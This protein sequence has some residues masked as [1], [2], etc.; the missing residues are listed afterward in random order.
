[1]EGSRTWG[2]GRAYAEAVCFF[3]GVSPFP[4]A[5]IVFAKP[6]LGIAGTARGGVAEAE[7]CGCIGRGVRGWERPR[8][9]EESALAYPLRVKLKAS[10]AWVSAFSQLGH[11]LKASA[12]AMW[13]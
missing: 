3:L 2:P 4:E 7:A 5:G 8:A 9:G 1:M 10:L 6:S 11:G 13:H 12:P